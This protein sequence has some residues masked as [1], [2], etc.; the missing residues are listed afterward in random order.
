ME[1][2]RCHFKLLTTPAYLEYI[3]IKEEKNGRNASFLC[4][5]RMLW[6]MTPEK[7]RTER[8]G[9]AFA[10]YGFYH[11]IYISFNLP[12]ATCICTKVW[13]TMLQYTPHT[14]LRIRCG[15]VFGRSLWSSTP[16][17]KF[18]LYVFMQ[19][20]WIL[21]NTVRLGRLCNVAT[22]AYQHVPTQMG[23]IFQ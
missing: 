2:S 6:P 11:I 18:Q 20:N 22:K 8:T 9:T 13:C 23:P 12:E 5:I 16:F 15:T 19:N 1:D 3:S 14:A 4:M 7:R 10:V 21:L 17:L